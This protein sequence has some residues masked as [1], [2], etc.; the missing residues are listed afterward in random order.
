MP[1]YQ[2][3]DLPSPAELVDSLDDELMDLLSERLKFAEM[4][5]VPTTPE[6]IERQV[7][8]MR[9]LAAIYHVPPDL[10]EKMARAIIDATKEVLAKKQKGPQV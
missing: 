8:R 10:G 5:P 6:E 4:L 1:L 2:R 9:N 3:P 7:Q